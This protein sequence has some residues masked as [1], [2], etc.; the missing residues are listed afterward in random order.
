[1]DYA[2]EEQQVEAIKNWWKEN[3]K[4]VIGG[5]LIGLAVL[6]GGRAWLQ[7]QGQH[8]ANASMVFETMMQDM[9]Q[10][11]AKQ[12]AESGAQLLGQYS[13][14]PYAP[15][16]ALTMAKIKADEGDLATAKLHLRYAQDNAKKDEIKHVARLRLARVLLA[17]GNKDEALKELDSAE[18]GSFAVSYEELKGDIYVAKGEVDNARNAYTLAL[19]AMPASDRG[20]K[21]LQM[22]LDDLG[23]VSDKGKPASP[24]SAGAS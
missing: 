3:A 4:S 23:E 24:A 17:E 2:T 9:A 16:A 20:R 12:A 11:K 10:D 21:F 14:T 13:D 22:K 7:Q 15:M 19:A 18:P 8:V 6:F 5:I 1:M